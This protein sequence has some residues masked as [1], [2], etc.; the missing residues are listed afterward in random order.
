[1]WVYK[2]ILTSSL[3][4]RQWGYWGGTKRIPSPT[5]LEKKASAA[6][7][8]NCYTWMELMKKGLEVLW[9]KH[10]M[11]PTKGGIQQTSDPSP[12]YIH[13]PQASHPPLIYTHS[14]PL[15]PSFFI[16]TDWKWTEPVGAG[17]LT[18]RLIKQ[19]RVFT[20]GFP[21]VLFW[22]FFRDSQESAKEREIRETLEILKSAKVL[23]C[24]VNTHSWH[25]LSFKLEWA[26]LKD[27][28]F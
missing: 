27:R 1:M 2:G 5:R 16:L 8:M 22:G 26:H 23:P 9:W 21:L 7:C 11:I 25:T 12:L 6:I 3:V 28:C 15:V 13:L 4:C 19:L 10:N 24:M 14:F 17:D 20:R 18:M